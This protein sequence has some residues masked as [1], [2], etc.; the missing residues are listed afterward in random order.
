MQNVQIQSDSEI[1][2]IMSRM[3]I[4]RL[5]TIITTRSDKLT[6]VVYVVISKGKTIYD[7]H[8]ETMRSA[9]FKIG[10]ISAGKKGVIDLQFEKELT[11]QALVNLEESN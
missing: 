7:F 6:Q 11:S 2:A 1:K 5:H 9:G 4:Q 8:L 3:D 10:A